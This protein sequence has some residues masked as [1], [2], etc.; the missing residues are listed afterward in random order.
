MNAKDGGVG[1]ARWEELGRPVVPSVIIDGAVSPIL[2]ISQIAFLLGLPYEDT[3]SSERVAW[4][5]VTILDGWLVNLYEMGW[6]DILAPTPSRERS[7]RN[8]TVNTFHP[9]ELLP[10][11]FREGRF[12]WYPETRDVELEQEIQNKDA[13]VQF[14]SKT[15]DEWKMFLFS[16]GQELDRVEPV[17]TSPRGDTTY[18]ALLRAQRWHAAWHHRQISDAA[19]RMGYRLPHRLSREM[20]ATLKLPKN[21]Y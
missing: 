4:D 21:I 15:L 19:R 6:K 1:R 3:D 18:P 12:L 5:T 11:A 10:G 20:R 17:V 16:S 8:L 7:T 13:L 9:F 2:H 14:A